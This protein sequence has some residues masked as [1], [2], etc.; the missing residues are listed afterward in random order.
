M[1]LQG[2]VSP[3]ARNGFIVFDPMAP[4]G[5]ALQR[6]LAPVGVAP[7]PDGSVYFV[8]NQL[9]YIEWVDSQ[10]NLFAVTS[11]D[12]AGYFFGDGGPASKAVL[13]TPSQA[14]TDS[15][16]NLFIADTGNNRI[17]RIDAATGIITTVAGNGTA[18]EC[19]D[20]GPA[21]QACI[22]TP[23]G[24][25]VDS[26]GTLYI[27]DTDQH[28]RKVA[29]NGIISTLFS[30]QSSNGNYLTINAAHNVFVTPFA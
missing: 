14:A 21:T 17:R 10:N 8:N 29:P 24:I 6:P 7:A 4:E 30:G 19:G 5:P 1:N 28:V 2:I 9:A 11:T 27:G 25:G 12:Q 16:G 3:F 18:A 23:Y 13:F 26:D 20:S 22:N 15:R